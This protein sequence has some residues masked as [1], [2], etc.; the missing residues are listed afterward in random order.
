MHTYIHTYKY[1]T[2]DDDSMHHSLQT[3]LLRSSSCLGRQGRA[4]GLIYKYK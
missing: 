4:E 1:S 2:D 3:L